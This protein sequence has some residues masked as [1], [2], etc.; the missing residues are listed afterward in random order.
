MSNK[1]PI[2]HGA[3]IGAFDCMFACLRVLLSACLSVNTGSSAV[4]N[5]ALHWIR[6]LQSQAAM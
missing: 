3:T 1:T 2:R 6:L 5:T 4:L